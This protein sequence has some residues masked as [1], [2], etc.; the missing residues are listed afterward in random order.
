MITLKWTLVFP[1]AVNMQ[2]IGARAR[3]RALARVST[4]LYAEYDVQKLISSASP[5]IDAGKQ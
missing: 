5:R 1:V 3:V 4:N 2:L